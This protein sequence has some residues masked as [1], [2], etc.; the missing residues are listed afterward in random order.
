MSQEKEGLSAPES[1]AIEKCRCASINMNHV[2]LLKSISGHFSKR[3]SQV[4]F[5]ITSPCM[6][7]HATETCIDMWKHATPTSQV[8]VS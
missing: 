5:L 6:W 3:S 1:G 4:I 8:V 7:K 2:S